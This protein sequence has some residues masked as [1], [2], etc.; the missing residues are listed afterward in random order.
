MS[1]QS[2]MWKEIKLCLDQRSVGQ[3]GDGSNFKFNL[4]E[5]MTSC[6][7]QAPVVTVAEKKLIVPFRSEIFGR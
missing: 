5:I 7:A 6:N 3:V 4:F 2:N 1:F